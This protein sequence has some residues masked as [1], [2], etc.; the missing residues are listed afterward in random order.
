MKMLRAVLFDLG[1]T[2]IVEGEDD[3]TSARAALQEISRNAHSR[4]FSSDPRKLVLNYVKQRRIHNR[5]RGKFN[6]EIH[7]RSWLSELLS[8]TFGEDA[9]EKFLKEAMETFIKFR[10][11]KL[12][13]YP[14]V[15]SVLEELSERYLLG[16]VTNISS[17]DVPHIALRKLGLEGLFRV[18]V[19]SAELGVRKP[20][21]WMFLYA[22]RM[23]KVGS[24][25]SVFVGNSLENDVQGAKTVG[26]KAV[27]V[28]REG[29]YNEASCAA[30]FKI[31]SLKEL[32]EVL[33]E[34][35]LHSSQL[36]VK[37]SQ[38]LEGFL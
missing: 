9:D 37:S 10:M 16:A 33:E 24:N 32:P 21:P 12:S 19:T 5:I 30:D 13:L 1:G 26:M 17:E 29:V 18:V 15:S 7:L 20:Y 28:D 2:L 6:V 25:E 27:L 36:K 23:L 8:S 4:N 11:M 31:K 34:I 14:E 38:K 35:Q 22:L 3:R